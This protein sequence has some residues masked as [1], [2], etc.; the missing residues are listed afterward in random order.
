MSLNPF[1]HAKVGEHIDASGW[2]LQEAVIFPAWVILGTAALNRELVTENQ[3]K[4]ADPTTYTQ[5]G[6]CC[7]LGVSYFQ[8]REDRGVSD[9]LGGACEAL[10]G[11]HRTGHS[12]RNG[13]WLQMK[14]PVCRDLS[15]HQA[16][17]INTHSCYI[18]GICKSVPHQPKRSFPANDFTGTEKGANNKRI[19]Q[20][21]SRAASLSCSF[22]SFWK[23]VWHLTP[24]HPR[25]LGHLAS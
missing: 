7:P 23:W 21:L 8:R 19:S 14:Q 22:P 6:L 11:T 17:Q 25:I 1:P 12:Q 3:S 20:G 9:S 4:Q 16:L 24:N 15:H 13:A 18:P 5:R 2:H 10:E